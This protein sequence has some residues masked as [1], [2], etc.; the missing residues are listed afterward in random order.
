MRKK[1]TS[2]GSTLTDGLIISVFEDNGPV[3]V[4]NSSPLNE[5][6]AF[7]MVLKALPAIGSDVPL[8]HGEIR[9]YGLIPTPKEPF[10][11]LSFIFILKAEKTD[12]SRIARFGRIIVFWIITRSSALMKYIGLIKRM[13]RREIQIYHIKND[14]DLKK[15]E[16]M[17]KIDNKIQIIEVGIE[18]YYISEMNSIEPFLDLAFVPKD[19]PIMMVD[20]PKNQIKVLLRS[21]S[22]PSRKLE[23]LQL[24]N[25]Y[26]K[27]IP[28]GP[29]YKTEII[30]DSL[31]VQQLLAK[32]GFITQFDV[33]TTIR[34]RFTNELTF[35]ELDSFFDFHLTPKRQQLVTQIMRTIESKIPLNLY[36]L[37]VQTGITMELIEEF[38][39]SALNSGLIQDFEIKNGTLTFMEE[40]E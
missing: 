13:I 7:N 35:E 15:E 3:N 28:K 27:N 22:N 12:D 23:L 1:N 10:L 19:A 20:K 25:D 17:R 24:V 26:K 6:E 4:Y 39:A 14:T 33:G 34:L 31:I 18:S 9:S 36:E 38:I 5:S 32:T 21:Q 8:E 30:S 11:C 16:I 2:S 29:I 37:S 40:V